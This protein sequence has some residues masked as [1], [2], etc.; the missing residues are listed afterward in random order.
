MT[1]LDVMKHLLRELFGVDP[2]RV[3]SADH[4]TD[5]HGIDRRERRR[6]E[7]EFVKHFPFA[8]GQFGACETIADFEKVCAR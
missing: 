3:E 7:Q 1:V 4:L 8:E 5:D 2:H 6:L